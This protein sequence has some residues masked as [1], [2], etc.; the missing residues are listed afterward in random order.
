[1]DSGPEQISDAEELRRVQRQARA[2][3]VK[4]IVAAAILTAAALVL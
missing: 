1:M 4:S 3:Y 2:V